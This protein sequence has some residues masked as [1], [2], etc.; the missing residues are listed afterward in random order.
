MTLMVRTQIRL[1]PEQ[2]A[3]L[4]KLSAERGVSV[5]HLIRVSIDE[6]VVRTRSQAREA[7]V[8]RAKRP[9]GQFASDSS[10]GSAEHDRYFADSIAAE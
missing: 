3:A 1:T 6:F 8:A 5:A 10:D 7:I 2:V 9:V 4:G